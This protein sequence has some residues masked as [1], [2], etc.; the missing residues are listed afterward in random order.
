MEWRERAETVTEQLFEEVDEIAAASDA[1]VT[2]ETAIGR[3]DREIINYA[4]ENDIGHIVIGSHGRGLDSRL[5]LGSVTEAVAFRS[6]VRVTL[7]R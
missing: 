1:E 5:L 4:A 2:T 3:A 6:P 7:V